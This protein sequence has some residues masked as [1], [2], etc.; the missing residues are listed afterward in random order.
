VPISSALN[1]S[2]RY[3]A[4]APLSHAAQ[5]PPP[6]ERHRADDSVHPLGHQ[7]LVGT[8]ERT[9]S[10]QRRRHCRAEPEDETIPETPSPKQA[11]TVAKQS[12][13]DQTTNIRVRRL[14]CANPGCA[15]PQ[16]RFA[17]TDEQQKE[18]ESRF[19]AGVPPPARCPSCRA[20]RKKGFQQAPGSASEPQA[21][22]R[23]ALDAGCP[24]SSRGARRPPASRRE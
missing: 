24:S 16:E 19:G 2:S 23:N 13:S 22:A 12:K 8:T 5:P 10:Q 15:N 6:C 9:G 3:R 17:W 7:A 4:P 18:L 20:Q 1:T 21:K 14:Q 11:A